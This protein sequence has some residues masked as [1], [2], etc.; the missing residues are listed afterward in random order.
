MFN[1]IA[2]KYSIRVG[3]LLIN[4]KKFISAVFIH[5]FQRSPLM[6]LLKFVVF[7]E[8]SHNK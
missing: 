7:P 3:T 2:K 5:E 6:G 1:K 8:K 4:L